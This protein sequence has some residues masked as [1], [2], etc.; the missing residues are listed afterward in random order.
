MG[1]VR[2]WDCLGGNCPGKVVQG[3]IV[4][5]EIVRVGIVRGG[6]VRSQRENIFCKEGIP[7]KLLGFQVEPYI[8]APSPHICYPTCQCHANLLDPL[9][10]CKR[11]S[12]YD[13][14]DLKTVKLYGVAVSG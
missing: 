5:G 14:S 11:S 8:Y 10:S 2:V 3:G 7:T 6:L 1:I 4:R 13:I 12:K 9:A